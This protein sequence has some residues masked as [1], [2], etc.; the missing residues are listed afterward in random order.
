M[1]DEEPEGM[2]EEER[3]A[4]EDKA[5]LFNQV[6]YEQRIK[7]LEE[8]NADLVKEKGML[9]DNLRQQRSDEADIYYYL[10]KKLDDNYDVIASLEKQILIEQTERE[11]AQKNYDEISKNISSANASEIAALQD[12]LKSTKEDL[13]TLSEFRQKKADLE[14][15]FRD[16]R[17]TMEKEQEEHKQITADLDRRNVQEKERL[18][19]EMLRKIQET[20][21]NL[22]SMTEDQLHTTTKR[23]IMENEQMITELQYQSK[24]TE[25]MLHKNEK[26]ETEKQ[27]LRR[28]LEL[29]K[30][31]EQELAK[32]TQFYQKLIKKL[33]EKLKAREENEKMRVGDEKEETKR[34]ESVTEANQEVIGALQDKTEQLEA[35]LE[36]V[37]TELEKTRTDSDL[38][39]EERDRMLTLQDETVRF[40]LTSMQDATEEMGNQRS[41]TPALDNMSVEQRQQVLRHLLNKLYEF[42]TS[43]KGRQA[44]GSLPPIKP[45]GAKAV[46]ANLEMGVS[47][48]DAIASADIGSN[49]SGQFSMQMGGGGEKVEARP[50][51]R[52]AQGI[53]LTQGNS[54]G[55]FLQ[56][57]GGRAAA[58]KAAQTRG[59]GSMRFK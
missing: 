3:K 16:L 14:K 33:H 24:E 25:K 1:A 59:G 42:Q 53:G 13:F 57:G 19:N 10:H 26:L 23:T 56:K 30:E 51:G 21:Q 50:W 54:P 2:T 11:R 5:K 7:I 40:L 41:P 43:L 34:L 31:T 18:K 39:Q 8:E 32:R 35:T 44:G 20:K 15:Q 38:M 9:E 46:G 12:E 4:A 45:Q 6:M 48:L 49:S 52:R 17:E 58:V 27:S 47:P 55:T 28:E 22:L 29:S 37:C 36:A